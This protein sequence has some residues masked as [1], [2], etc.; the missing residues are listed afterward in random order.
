MIYKERVP[1]SGEPSPC[2]L[3]SQRGD[4]KAYAKNSEGE[5]DSACLRHEEAIILGGAE[6]LCRTASKNRDATVNGLLGVMHSE[7]VGLDFLKT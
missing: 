7:S 2:I 6:I 4:A 3:G 1:T 5:E